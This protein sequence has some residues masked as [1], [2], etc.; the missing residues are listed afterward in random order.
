VDIRRVHTACLSVGL[1]LLVAINILFIVDIELTLRRNNRTDEEDEW[2]FGQVLALLLL[3]V[4]L[5]DAWK[6]LADIQNRFQQEFDQAFQTVVEAK[7]LED[8]LGYLESLVAQ[9]ADL[10]KPLSGPFANR[11]QMAAYYGKVELVRWVLSRIKGGGD[12][13]VN[14]RG[15]SLIVYQR[16]GANRFQGEIMEQRS[17]WHLRRAMTKL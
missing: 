6:A 16:G 9:G 12:A 1:L 4:P 11:L 15:T 10:G 13:V 17:R 3:L 2:G 14:F 7:P 5:R 8:M